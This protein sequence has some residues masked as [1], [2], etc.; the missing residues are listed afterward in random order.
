MVNDCLNG[1][2]IIY[3]KSI[4]DPKNNQFNHENLN[5]RLKR[6]QLLTK[7]LLESKTLNLFYDMGIFQ[8]FLAFFS[9]F[10]EVVLFSFLRL[11]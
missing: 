7:F 2:L 8:K 10:E 1:N 9:K 11:F 5:F 6:H 4:L 3:D